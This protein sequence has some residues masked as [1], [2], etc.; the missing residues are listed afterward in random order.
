M[1][2]KLDWIALL[3]FIKKAIKAGNWSTEIVKKTIEF[4]KK[5]KN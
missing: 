5:K 4:F 3:N 2:E 1:S